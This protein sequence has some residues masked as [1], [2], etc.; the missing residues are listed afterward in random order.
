MTEISRSTKIDI[1]M[2]QWD[3]VQITFLSNLVRRTPKSLKTIIQV[4][5]PTKKER[6]NR[7]KPCPSRMKDLFDYCPSI[8]VLLLSSVPIENRYGNQ[9]LERVTN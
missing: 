9:I 4:L 2:P 3:N 6:F 5:Y 7:K 1:Y 8:V